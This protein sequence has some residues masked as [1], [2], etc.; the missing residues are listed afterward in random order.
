MMGNPEGPT[1]WW[2]VERH[3]DRR[4][5]LIART[6]I[7]RALRAWFDAA[8]FVPVECAQLVRAPG[9][10]TH[11]HAFATEARTESGARIPLYLHTSPEFAAKRLL[12]AGETK[13]VD[14]ARVFRNRERG[15]L[16]APEFTLVEW[17]RSHA[18]LAAVMEDALELL[19]VAARAVDGVLTWNART[20]D[21][22]ALPERLT[23]ASAFLRYAGVDLFAAME[24]GGAPDRAAL[25]CQAQGIGIRFNDD[26][27]WSDIFSRILTERVEPNLGWSGPCL[28]TEYPICE[29]ALARPA[30]HDPRVAE[31][32]ELYVGGVELANGFGELTDVDEQ[33]R[34]F[35]HDMD[36][37][38][39]RYGERFPIDEDFLA[40]LGVMPPASGVAL[41]FDR[42]VMLAVGAQH[43]DQVL[44]TPATW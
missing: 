19:K 32:F 20:I 1:P 36:E 11:L 43:I 25:A 44:W 18:P 29:A 6:R 3:A 12:A 4:P 40:A 41:G 26:D 27:T 2:R 23:V 8:D 38:E 7:L 30:S 10:E 22:W 34:R 28:L 42:L 37:K 17:Y 13:I 24:P 21:P 35:L 31:R 39:R 5:A 14:V 9:G 33:R 15:R 16:H